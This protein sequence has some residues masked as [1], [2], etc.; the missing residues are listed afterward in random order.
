MT[1]G[2][3]SALLLYEMMMTVPIPSAWKE[4]RMKS[5]T[6]GTVSGCV[7]VLILVEVTSCMVNTWSSASN[8]VGRFNE[9]TLVL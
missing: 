6:L 5:S 9:R 4:V 2:T 7:T 8:A 1:L 3:C